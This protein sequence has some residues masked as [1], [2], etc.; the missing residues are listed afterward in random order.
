[1][2][3]KTM[4]QALLFEVDQVSDEAVLG[5]NCNTHRILVPGKKALVELG[6][7]ARSG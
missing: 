2:I 7:Q 1:M 3:D 4:P 5:T 6:S